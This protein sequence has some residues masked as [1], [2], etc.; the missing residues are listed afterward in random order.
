[1]KIWPSSVIGVSRVRQATSREPL[2]VRVVE[3]VQRGW[4]M[5][6]P[7]VGIRQYFVNRNERTLENGVLL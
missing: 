6:C 5:N 4:P 2:L 1:M 7:I 3:F